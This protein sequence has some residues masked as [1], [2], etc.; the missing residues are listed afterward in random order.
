MLFPLIIKKK[1]HD[2]NVCKIIK[3][4]QD[5]LLRSEDHLI[6]YQDIRRARVLLGL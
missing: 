5:L 4:H 3:A 1:K 6:K 2:V